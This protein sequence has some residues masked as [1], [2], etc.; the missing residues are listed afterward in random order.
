M[1]NHLSTSI[2]I[3]L[4]SASCFSNPL[5][6]QSGKLNLTNTI[7]LKDSLFWTTYNNC[8]IET[9]PQFFTEDVEFY[10]DKG[11]LTLGMKNLIKDLKKNLCSNPNFKLKREAIK[12]SIKVYPL[13][14]SDVIYGAIISGEHVFHILEKG[15]EA[16]LDGLAKFTHVWILSDNV[17]KMS[18]ILSYDHRPVPYVSQRKVVMQADKILDQFIG[19]YGAPQSGTCNVQRENDLL[20][21]IFGDQKYILYPQSDN[22]F[23]TKEQDLTF[24]F[25]KDGKGNVLNMTVRENGKI[26]EIAVRKN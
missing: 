4:L 12:R 14:D 23:F 17:W 21:L 9:M 1:T 18:R 7:L 5:L 6:A 10:H 8:D 3:F 11:G 2:A 13:Q 22:S 26:V 25:D 15:K 20:H 19:Q 24:E 16:R